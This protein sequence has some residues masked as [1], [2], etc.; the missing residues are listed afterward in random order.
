MMTAGNGQVAQQFRKT[1]K[2]RVKTFAN[3][4]FNVDTDKLGN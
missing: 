3:I 1:D 4:V 2:I